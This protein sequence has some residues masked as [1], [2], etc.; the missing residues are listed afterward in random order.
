MQIRQNSTNFG[1]SYKLQT[2]N[3][4]DADRLE[5]ILSTRYNVERK[6]DS[7]KLFITPKNEYLMYKKVSEDIAGALFPHEDELNSNS[8]VSHWARRKEENNIFEQ[9]MSKEK[10]NAIDLTI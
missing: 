5:L 6:K 7:K 8:I 4:D 9:I 3:R 10:K 1:Q 2:K